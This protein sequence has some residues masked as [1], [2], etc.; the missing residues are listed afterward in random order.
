VLEP[1]LSERVITRLMGEALSAE[2]RLSVAK[3]FTAADVVVAV[4]PALYGRPVGELGR[5][6]QRILAVPDCVPLL[7]V[8][9]AR[10]RTYATAAAL[11]TE[12]AVADLVARG[13][14]A[15]TAAVVPDE[16]VEAAVAHAEDVLGR[17]LSSGQTK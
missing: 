14:G 13:T 15:A 3:V 17:P 12:G 9:G 4:G 2:G 11:A 5:L 16:L 1:G 7:G 6:V 10:E 8:K